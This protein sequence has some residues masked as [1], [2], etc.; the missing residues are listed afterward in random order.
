MSLNEIYLFLASLT[1]YTC[2]SIQTWHSEKWNLRWSYEGNIDIIGSTSVW[3]YPLV[4]C[5][6]VPVVSKSGW[7]LFRWFWSCISIAAVPTPHGTIES[8]G[9]KKEQRCCAK[10]TAKQKRKK[11]IKKKQKTKREQRQ[12]MPRKA[13]KAR[14]NAIA[15]I[16]M[17]E[18]QFR[19]QFFFFQRFLQ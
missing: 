12:H 19:N 9:R 10:T 2:L 4:C 7:F 1:S 3:N 17:K 16:G 15:L 6:M 18:E 11:G 14:N 5:Y 13:S 8:E